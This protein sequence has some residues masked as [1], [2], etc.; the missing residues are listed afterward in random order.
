MKNVDFQQLSIVYTERDKVWSLCPY[1]KDINRPNLSISL[2]DNYYGRWKCWACGR[3]GCL[4]K[5]QMSN[6]N[7]SEPAIYK[8][9]DNNLLTRWQ[10]FT[11]DCY[12]NL[13]RFPLLKLGFAEQLNISTN[14]LDD[15]L[16]GFDGNS[17]TI[18]MFRED[19]IEY[20]SQRGTCGVQRRF[21][22]GSKRCITGSRLGLMYPYEQ[23]G[24]YYIF[25]CEGFSDGISV[26]D[27]GLNSMARPYCRYTEGIEEFLDD[28]LEGID[29]IIIVPDSDTVGIQGAKDLQYLLGDNYDCKIFSFGGAKDVR[30]YIANIGKP[31][32][33]KELLRMV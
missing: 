18:P 22:D 29:T 7:L 19:L 16:V 25:I 8:N 6:L 9:N 24:D 13:K 15:W 3:N 1:H 20:Y 26:Y 33:K 10:Q 12:D 28:I 23:I 5:E 2:L 30:E 31:R 21:S 27:L 17:F 14:S 4:S 32:A 11:E